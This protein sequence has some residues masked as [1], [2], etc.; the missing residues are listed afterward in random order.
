MTKT[1]IV[2]RITGVTGKGDPGKVVGMVLDSRG[3]AKELEHLVHHSPDG[4]EFGYAGSGPADLARSIVGD[5]LRTHQPH[6]AD[7]QPVKFALIATLKGDGPHLIHEAAIREHIR[8]EPDEPNYCK[9]HDIYDC[10]Y[11]HEETR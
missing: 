7:Y 9:T 11:A 4:F 2:R 6:P 3:A 10:P 5:L 1:Y 8:A